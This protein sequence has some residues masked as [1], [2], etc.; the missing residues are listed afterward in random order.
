[1]LRPTALLLVPVLVLAA[2]DK[3]PTTAA[4]GPQ[5]SQVPQADVRVAGTMTYYTYATK[6]KQVLQNAVWNA[7]ATVEFLEGQA[8][9]VSLNE[10]ELGRF[11]VL[12]GEMTPS[13][14]LTMVYVMPPGDFVKEIVRGHSGCT[15]AGG[16]PVYHG[17]FDGTRLVADTK[18][19]S[20]CP[21]HWEPND[22]FPTPVEG[23]VHWTWAIDMMVTP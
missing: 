20:R 22:I 15:I 21:I 19:N 14:E 8:I 13:G 3:P 11:T 4:P 10:Y 7:D 1:M 12:E 17:R 5:F 2:C 16:F 9:R 18:F 23:S 6:A